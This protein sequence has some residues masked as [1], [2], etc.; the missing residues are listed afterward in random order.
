MKPA[1]IV[2]TALAAQVAAAQD[3][4]TGVPAG[5]RAA[6]ASATEGLDY[7]VYVAAESADQVYKIVFDGKKARV[8]KVIDVGYQPTEI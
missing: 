4:A 6:T 1:L 8:L 3:P 5:R 7:Y 2:L